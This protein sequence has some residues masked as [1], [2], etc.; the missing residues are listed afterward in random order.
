MLA[1]DN[2]LAEMKSIR[3]PEDIKKKNLHGILKVIEP[4]WNPIIFKI[5]WTPYNCNIFSAYVLEMNFP[6]TKD[7][8]SIEMI[9]GKKYVFKVKSS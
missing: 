2:L 4:W 6:L 9:T 5:V 3:I 7:D 8:G 1:E